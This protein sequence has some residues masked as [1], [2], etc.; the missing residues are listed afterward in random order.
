MALDYW[1]AK[2]SFQRYVVSVRLPVVFL[3]L[4]SLLSKLYR[5]C[6]EDKRDEFLTLRR[7]QRLRKISYY[8]DAFPDGSEKWTVSGILGSMYKVENPSINEDVASLWS[9]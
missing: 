4:L 2:L 1:R 9:K 3:I 8:D 5:K 7:Y 6:V